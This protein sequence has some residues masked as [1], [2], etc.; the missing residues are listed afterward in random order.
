MSR[1]PQRGEAPFI[2]HLSS[3]HS[4]PHVSLET[5]PFWPRATSS[6]DVPRP[7]AAGN[8]ICYVHTLEPTQLFESMSW[9]TSVGTEQASSYALRS[10]KQCALTH[11]CIRVCICTHVRMCRDQ[12]WNDGQELGDGDCLQ[13]WHGLNLSP[14]TQSIFPNRRGKWRQDIQADCSPRQC[15][16]FLGILGAGHRHESK[17][18]GR[19][20]AVWS[21]EDR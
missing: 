5:R 17:R 21:W 8:E 10:K 11:V 15:L 7:P 13:P 16:S 18:V 2:I 20:L 4:S 9:K 3:A 19:D 6:T 14:H 1:G 12:L